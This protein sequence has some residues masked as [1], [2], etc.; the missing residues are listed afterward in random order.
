MNSLIRRGFKLGTAQHNTS[1]ARSQVTERWTNGYP[2]L[3]EKAAKPSIEDHQQAI[4]DTEKLVLSVL[5]G[6]ECLSFF[7]TSHYKTRLAPYFT[8]LGC[9]INEGDDQEIET[10]LFDAVANGEVVGEDLWMKVSWLSFEEEDASLRFRF[11]FGV[12]HEEDVAAD[13]ARQHYAA[14]LTNAIFPESTIITENQSLT[15]ALSGLLKCDNIRYVERIVYFNAPNGGAYLHHD[16]ERGHAGVAFAQ[17]SGSTYWLALPKNAL[18]LEIVKFV[19]A[20]IWP[21]TLDQ[22]ARE[23]IRTLAKN[24]EN[25]AEELDS[26]ANSSLVHLINETEAFVQQLIRNGHGQELVAGDVLLLPQ[27]DQDTCCWHSV[28]CLGEQMG[29][30]L[31]FAI[32]CGDDK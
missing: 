27:H 15:A 4:L 9:A 1:Y 6:N 22:T 19:D 16:L 13:S 32:R 17:L 20:D 30:A 8:P 3:L 11:S 21:E 2:V 7:N 31:S 29:Q 5:E 23:E 25:L 18:I 14:Q 26:F 12:D 24:P 28:F 10:V